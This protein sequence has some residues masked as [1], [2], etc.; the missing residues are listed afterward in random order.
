MTTTKLSPFA[1]RILEH[2]YA[3]V[4]SDGTKES[5][6]EIAY[7]VVS[8]V[9]KPYFPDLVGELTGLIER[10]EFIPGGRYLY[11]AGRAFCQTQNC[12][13]LTVKDSREGWANLMRRATSGLMT[14]AG[15]GVVYDDIRPNGSLVRGMGGKCSGPLALMNMVNEAGRYIMQGG[16][17]RSAVWA[18]LRWDHDDIFDFIRAKNWDEY[19]QQAK[20]KDFNYPAPLDGTNISVR[21]DDRFFEAYY[22]NDT[23]AHEVYNT[24]VRRMLKTGEPG[25]SID[26]GEDADEKLRNACTEVTSADDDD[27]CN[28]GSV[29]LSRIQDRRHMAHVVRMGTLFLMCGT[30]Y[31]EVPYGEVA[32][33]RAKN[34][35]LGLG[36]MGVHEWILDNGLKYGPSEELGGLLQEYTKSTEYANEIA[37]QLGIS[38]PVKTRAIAPTGTISIIAE[39]TSGIEPIFC[40]AFKR[41]YLKGHTWFSQ[42]VIDAA[43]QRLINKGVKAEDIEDAMTLATD[44]ERRIAFQAWVQ[45]YVDHGIS[46]TLN[47]P[48]WGSEHNNSDGVAVFGE[49]LMK[50][51]P[52]LRGITCYPSDSRSGQPLTRVDYSE[53]IDNYGV[54]FEEH[55]N[56]QSC[57]SGACGV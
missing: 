16:S 44:P 11:A 22:N 12:L 4:K 13:L 25:F 45:G 14:G 26:L 27:I 53:A 36:L 47:L 3:H 8:N 18:G 23:F 48:A 21:L 46:S 31:S 5:W 30:L 9:V 38:R 19:T 24:A 42:Y 49:M 28:L 39:T 57:V 32:D 7:R 17:R 2:K 54:E 37:D 41:R 15:I 34:R 52:K 6:S 20:V 43:A 55:G 10:R 50:Y 29:N 56:E 51:L 35:R 1:H 40:V 33:T